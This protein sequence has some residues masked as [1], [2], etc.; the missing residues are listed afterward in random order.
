[1]DRIVI[2][3]ARWLALLGG[4]ALVAMTVIL[5]TSITG[6][7]LIAVGLSPIRG[8]YE[9]I[10]G[11][12]AFAVF[13]FL[14]W[15][16]VT[17]AHATVDAFT[18]LLPDMANRVIDIV[19]EATMTGLLYLLTWRLYVGLFDKMRR[20]DT[21]FILGYPTWWVFAGGLIGAVIACLVSTW[22]VW[23]RI[24]GSDV[25]APTATEVEVAR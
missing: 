12:S 24:R 7:A 15:C 20:G 8:D 17:R 4:L 5:C 16:Q 18:Q 22:L 3:T 14:P 6:R 10:E 21:S 25:F 23:A 1:M 2:T 13:S 19:T 9:I 11:L